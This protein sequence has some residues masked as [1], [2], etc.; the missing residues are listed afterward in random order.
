MI[1]KCLVIGFFSLVAM[2]ALR[3]QEVSR[4]RFFAGAYYSF[5]RNPIVLDG[6]FDT[7]YSNHHYLDLN[8]R[9]ALNRVWRVGVEYNLGFVSYKDAENPFSTLGATLDYD[10]LRARRSKLNLRVG[11][12]FSNLSLAADDPPQKQ[13]VVNR[14]LG[15]SY[16]YRINEVFWINAGFY[17]HY[18]WTKVSEK[19]AMIQPFIGVSVGW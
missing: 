11:I 10:I 1:Y 6:T 17:H 16:E 13:F 3:G 14:I 5:D 4:H 18:P 12:S 8:F 9:Y 2:P 15:G 7:I 19:Y